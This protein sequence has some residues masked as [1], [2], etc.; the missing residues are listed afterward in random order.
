MSRRL[1]FGVVLSTIVLLSAT[2]ISQISFGRVNARVEKALPQEFSTEF[3]DYK[4]SATI[5]G[6]W[7]QELILGSSR[8]DIL[9]GYTYIASLSNANESFTADR[10]LERLWTVTEGNQAHHQL[11]RLRA[12]STNRDAY[13]FRTVRMLRTGEGKA[14]VMTMYIRLDANPGSYATYMNS[15]RLKGHLPTLDTFKAEPK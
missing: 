3:G 8:N 14:C 2:L 13:F 4:I 9:L 5:P 1:E 15:R 11:Y 7:S 6:G 10:V 12:N